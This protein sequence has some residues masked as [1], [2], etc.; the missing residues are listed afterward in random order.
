MVH[1]IINTKAHNLLSDK[2]VVILFYCYVNLN[3]LKSINIEDENLAEDS[4][5]EDILGDAILLDT[6]TKKFLMLMKTTKYSC[7][8]TDMV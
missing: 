2:N 7:L 8:V 6:E 3:L 4:G 5:L 1:K